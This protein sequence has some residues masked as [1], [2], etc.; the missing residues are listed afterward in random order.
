MISYDII[1]KLLGGLGAFLIGFKI[2][3]ET[4]ESLATNRL[5]KLFDKS[6][7]NPL[8]GV[9]IGIGATALMQ[10]SSATTVIVVGFVNAGLMNLYQATAV[11]MGANIGTTITAQLVALQAFD[12]S[13]FAIGLTAIGIFLNLLCKKKEKISQ[14]G[15]AIAG[16]GLIFLGVSYMSSQ[17]SFLASDESVKNAFETINNP[18]VL[19]LIG[20]AVTALVQSSFAVTSIVISLAAAGIMIGG[21]GNGV[22]YVILGTNIGT[23]VT[24]I[25]SSIGGSSNTKRAAI[26]HLLFNL[27]GSL[28]FMIILLLIPSF[29]EVTFG[30]WFTEPATQIAMF[31]TFF[32]VVCVIIFL[33]FINVFIKIAKLITPEKEIAKDNGVNYLD[34]RFLKNPPIALNQVNKQLVALGRDS[35]KSLNYAFSSFV[36]K[37]NSSKGEIDNLNQKVFSMNTNIIDYLIKISSNDLSI[38][39]EKV[40]SSYYH[41]LADIVRISELSDNI[42]KYTYILINNSL[43]FSDI[44]IEQLGEMME[45][46]NVMAEKVFTLMEYHD[47]SLIK[48]IEEYEQKIDTLRK[49]VIDGHIKRLTDGIC[50]AQ[51]NTVFTNLVANLERAADHFNFIAH[52]YQN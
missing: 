30:A 39:D 41:S 13:T 19:L 48:S 36:K 47:L 45:S 6:S 29:H 25:L 46:I 3:S 5:K 42:I 37:D 24:A 35:L 40:I 12:F 49:D 8:V 51:S 32:N 18:V 14:L 21:V 7:K 33:P 15:Y 50:L 9:G 38:R 10:S 22:Y 31:H 16:L 27:V 52:N 34:E 4:I 44:V 23:C 28:I 20:M 2:L 1:L 11:I 26:I 43:S 17:M